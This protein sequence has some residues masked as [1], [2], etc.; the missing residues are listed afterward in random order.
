MNKYVKKLVT[1]YLIVAMT[2]SLIPESMAQGQTGGKTLKS[3]LF[4]ASGEMVEP[5]QGRVT[6]IVQMEGAAR[7]LIS[8]FLAGFI[9][10]FSGIT[11][12]L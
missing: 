3:R 1:A 9:M 2:V 10:K 7:F 5:S 8:P 12:I 4:T 11:M 6:V